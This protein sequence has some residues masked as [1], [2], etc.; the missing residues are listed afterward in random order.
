M[1]E[2]LQEHPCV[3][4]GEP[5]PV[6]LEFDHLDNKVMSIA[7]ARSHGWSIE[8]LKTEIAKCEVRCANCHRKKTAIQFGW[9]ILEVIA[10]CQAG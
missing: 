10:Q 6:V 2:Y 5:D 4:C 7:R 1:T 3:D 9:Y 8:R